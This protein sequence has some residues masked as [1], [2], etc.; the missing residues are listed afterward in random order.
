[1]YKRN[2]LSFKH[3]GMDRPTKG[4]E[5]FQAKEI[6]LLSGKRRSDG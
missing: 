5:S 3:N 4:T 6:S 2:K 1:M